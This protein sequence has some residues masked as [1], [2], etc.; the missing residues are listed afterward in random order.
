MLE[1]NATFLIAIF[2]FIIFMILMNLV[3]Y[4][5]MREIVEK[6][7]RLLTENEKSVD[8]NTRKIDELHKIKEE[9]LNET[10]IE[11]RAIISEITTQAKQEKNQILSDFVQQVRNEREAAYNQL[12]SEISNAKT[13]LKDEVVAF[14]KEIADKISGHSVICENVEERDIDEVL[15]DG[16]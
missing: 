11:A 15:H 6:R 3:L 5:P 10:R 13:E 9:K 7:E 8:V 16:I 1:F 2:S 14:A 12:E 4:K